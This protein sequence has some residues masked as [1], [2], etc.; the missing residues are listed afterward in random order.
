L[1]KS[2]LPMQHVYLLLIVMI[3]WV[4]FRSPTLSGAIGFLKGM[5]GV[6]RGSGIQYHLSLYLDAELVLAMTAGVIGMMPTTTVIREYLNKYDRYNFT[7]ALEAIGL[8]SILIISLAL[9]ANS[10]FN[11]FIYQQF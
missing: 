7:P 9:Q 3:S 4:F 8:L 5:I 2:W 6:A 10:T 1:K 11:S